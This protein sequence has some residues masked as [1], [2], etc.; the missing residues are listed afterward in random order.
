MAY[1]LFELNKYIFY[2]ILHDI[3]NMIIKEIVFQ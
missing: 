2:T 1:K 3:G